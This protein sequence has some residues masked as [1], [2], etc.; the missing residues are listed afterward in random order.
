VVT[1]GSSYPWLVEPVMERRPWPSP[2]RIILNLGTIT[3]QRLDIIARGCASA[4]L[5]L[6]GS[7]YS[8]TRRSALFITGMVSPSVIDGI[9]YA[10][11]VAGTPVAMLM[12]CFFR[13]WS[14][15]D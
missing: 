14:P 9:K 3:E 1:P 15:F 5:Q 8:F 7:P 13:Y 12:C 6:V 2:T 4:G 10:A 11:E